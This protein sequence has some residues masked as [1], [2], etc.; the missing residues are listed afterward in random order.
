MGLATPTGDR[1]RSE[2][3]VGDMAGRPAAAAATTPE[4]ALLELA[5]SSPACLVIPDCTP[6]ISAAAAVDVDSQ[7]TAPKGVIPAVSF[8]APSDIEEIS[9]I[10]LTLLEDIS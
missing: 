2:R 7:S 5:D 4:D 8:P 9:P 6:T 1:V 3:F 10:E